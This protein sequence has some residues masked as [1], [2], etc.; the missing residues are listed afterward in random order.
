MGLGETFAAILA[1]KF[2]LTSHYPEL[3]EV[4]LPG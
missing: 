2:K 4:V 1:V 3:V